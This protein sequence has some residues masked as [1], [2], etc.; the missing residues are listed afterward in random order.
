M[1]KILIISSFILFLSCDKTTTTNNSDEDIKFATKF[2]TKF[3]KELSD[4]DTLKIYKSLDKSILVNDLSKLLKKNIRDYG[5]LKKVDV[6][7]TKTTNIT[8]NDISEI[9]YT[10]EALVTYEKSNNIEKLSFKK[11]NG[12]DAKVT[13]YLTQEIIE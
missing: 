6:K 10:I 3:Y 9:E 12:E 2:A 13:G 5:E 7:N 8:K 1:K 4:V 11:C